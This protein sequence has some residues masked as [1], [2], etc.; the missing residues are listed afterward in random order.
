MKGR[1][2][3]MAIVSVFLGLT[4]VFWLSGRW[5]DWLGHRELE[6]RPVVARGEFS[7]DEQNTIDVFQQANYTLTVGIVSAL[8]RSLNEETGQNIRGLFQ[9][10]AA[11]NPG[12]SGG[13]LLDSA[14]RLIG[15]NTAIYSPSGASAGIGFAV[16]VDTVARIV[17]R[18]IRDGEYRL[19]G[20]GI[21]PDGRI[22]QIV[23]NRYGIDG[24][25]VLGVAADSLAEEFGLIPARRT[26]DRSFV[27]EDV[28]VVGTPVHSLMDIGHAL[29]EHQ[30][31]ARMTIVCN[32]ETREV[33]P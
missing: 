25:V 33:C 27:L 15:I 2:D 18:L 19:P 16:P 9:T 8:D 10:D 22:N 13:P 20:L 17:P 12:N 4:A 23:S 26:R 6:Y 3:W 24:V 30:S 11:I 28:V 1:V 14:G 7:Q 29:E 21:T 32:G 31:P 5:Q